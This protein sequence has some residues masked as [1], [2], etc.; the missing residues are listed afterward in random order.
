MPGVARLTDVA[1]AA[2]CCAP[3]KQLDQQGA[4]GVRRQRRVDGALHVH[5]RL[6]G[7]HV[8]RQREQVGQERLRQHPQPDV[9]VDPARLEEVDAGR[10]A[11]RSSSAVPA[12]SCAS[13]MTESRLSPEVT[14]P[15]SSAEN[16]R[17]PPWWVLTVWSLITTV[18]LTMTPSKSTM[19]LL[20]GRAR[21]EQWPAV[22][23]APVDPHLLPRADVP[24]APGERS[25]HVRQRDRREAAVVVE[26]ALR[27]RHVLPAEQPVRVQREVTGSWAAARSTATC[28][29]PGRAAAARRPRPRRSGSPGS[30]R[31]ARAAAWPSPRLPAA[32]PRPERSPAQEPG[33]AAWSP[34]AGVSSPPSMTLGGPD[35]MAG[36]TRARA[37]SRPSGRYR[38]AGPSWVSAAERSPPP[39]ARRP[40]RV[41]ARTMYRSSPDPWPH[42][43]APRRPR[44]R[45][46]GGGSASLSCRRVGPGGR[47]VGPGCG[48]VGPGCGG[49]AVSRA[50]RACRARAGVACCWHRLNHGRHGLGTALDLTRRGPGVWVGNARL[51]PYPR[52]KRLPVSIRHDIRTAVWACALLTGE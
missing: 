40:G 13:T 18:A 42:P 48:G 29:R 38:P 50:D 5:P 47:G 46:P 39:R 8:G 22:E 41:S 31:A 28:S 37:G 16:G 4:V 30:A 17:Y 27:A 19:I 24:V 45:W 33:G 21:T 6:R 3:S 26:R 43:L 2:T 32:L 44:Q 20:P 7:E 1:W 52:C 23:M 15:V 35:A 36:R 12:G 9:T 51:H 25:D 34:G 49:R 14:W 11:A 10:A